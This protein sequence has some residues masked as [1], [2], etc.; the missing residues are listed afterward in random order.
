[1]LLEARA[2]WEYVASWA[3][4]PWLVRGSPGDAH[5]VIVLPGFLASDRSTE[6]MR[7]F[8]RARGYTPY[9]WGLGT[10]RGPSGGVRQACAELVERVAERH[11]EKVSLVGWSLGGVYARE[12]AKQHEAQTRCVIT[13]GSPF[14]GQSRPSRVRAAYERHNGPAR[15]DPERA[16]RISTAPRVPTTSIYSRTDGV[17]DWRCSLNEAEA[18]TEN[19]EVNASHIGMGVNPLVLYAIADRLRQDPNQ[20]QRF[21]ARVAHRLFFR[22]EQARQFRED[23]A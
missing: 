2:P 7:R 16:A 5:P 12:I 3:A 8:L 22:G 17:V 15:H 4:M 10:N 1:M 13:L 23:Q 11:G 20:W 21:D 18:H 19:I 9:G 6:P 14:T